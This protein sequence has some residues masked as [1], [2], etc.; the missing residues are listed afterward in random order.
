VTPGDR[1]IASFALRIGVGVAVGALLLWLAFA[2]TDLAEL[3]SVLSNL[4]Y[5]WIAA[6]V[7]FYYLALALRTFRWWMILRPSVDLALP[8][9]GQALI[10]GYAVNVLLPA[11]L[12]ELFRADFCRR[13][14][15][16]SR[17]KVLGTIMVERF[18][19]GVVV[20]VALGVGVLAAGLD[21][22]ST[23]TF[24]S[25]ALVGLAIFAS[26]G[27]ALFLLGS[28]LGARLTRRVPAIAARFDA[29]SES[30][31]LLRSRRMLGVLAA[32]VV[33]WLADGA[34]LWAVL[35][36]CGVE[37]DVLSMCLVIGIVSLSTLLPSPPGFLGTMQF[38]FALAVST[39]GYS[40]S[41]GL[42]AASV[43]Q[44]FLL[45]S[46]VVIGLL[47]LLAAYSKR[48]YRDVTTGAD[49]GTRP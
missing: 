45:G 28:D 37:L 1:R 42:A 9:V 44:A 41:Q 17:T 16:V 33:I 26:F 38:A 8:Q 46:M 11:R 34:A 22:D 21:A 2:R 14:Y 29:L 24:A 4:S 30:L 32:S 39:L 10:T 20:L 7:A 35:A 48:V 47:V 13:Q 40:W 19:D 25:V 31:A 3:A 23:G 18:T 12:G 36:S 6:A 5:G 49:G 43:N 27:A 15:G